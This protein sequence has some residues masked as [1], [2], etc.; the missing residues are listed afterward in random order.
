MRLFLTS[1]DLGNYKEELLRL[2][3]GSKTLLI[4]NA[5]DYYPPEKRF[6]DIQEK[7]GVLTAAGFDVEELDLKDYFGKPDSLRAKIDTFAPNLIFAVGG[8]TFL[9]STA[10][11]LSGFDKLV[12]DDLA[13]DKYVYGGNSA[14]A[15]VTVKTLRF[16]GHDH[17]SPEVVKDIYDVDAVLDGLNLI[18]GYI[19]AHADAPQHLETTKMYV[20]RIEDAGEKPIILNQ[21][22]AYIVNGD[23]VIL[24]D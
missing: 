20:K 13:Q 10:F 21:T 17:L 22:G 9:L 3:T 5:R 2:V 19:I 6:S 1:H 15:M 24:Y 8:N 14:G 4:S 7:I 18:D 23:S 16:Y 12:K 11:Y